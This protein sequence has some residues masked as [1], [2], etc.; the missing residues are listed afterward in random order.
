M[1]TRLSYTH[2]TRCTCSLLSRARWDN[3]PSSGL[4]RWRIRLT[5]IE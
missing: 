2:G 3:Q 1:G 5:S 4:S